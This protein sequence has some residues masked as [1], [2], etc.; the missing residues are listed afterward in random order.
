MQEKII[1]YSKNNCPNCNL[2]KWGLDAEELKYDERNIDT[3]PQWKAE[4]DTYGYSSAPLTIFPDGTKIAGFEHGK[5][6]D[7]I[8]ALKA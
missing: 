2:V 3:N 8:L 5:L 7:A 4:F 1:I 6:S